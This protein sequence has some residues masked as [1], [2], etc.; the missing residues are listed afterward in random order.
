MLTV[1]DNVGGVT[2]EAVKKGETTLTLDTHYTK[3]TNTITI[4]K[5]YLETLGED[6]YNFTVETDKGDTE[7]VIKIIDTTTIYADPD[8][9]IFDKNT[10][11]EDYKDIEI[12]VKHNTED[13]TLSSVKNGEST[14]EADTD[15]TVEGLKVTI[16]K[17]F[18]AEITEESVTITFVTNKGNAEAVITIE[19]SADVG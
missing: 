17:E 5:T 10:L 11:G 9:A 7:A 4:K 19:D 14:L 3:T 6:E 15:Y 12:E 18:L 13:V 8:T 2:I 16:A 1:A